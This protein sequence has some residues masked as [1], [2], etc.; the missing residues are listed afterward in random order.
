[1]DCG[2]SLQNSWAEALFQDNWRPYQMS[3]REFSPVRL[4]KE[5]HVRSHEGG[6]KA[7]RQAVCKP[8]REALPETKSPDTL[9]LI[10]PASGATRNRFLLLTPCRLL[11][12]IL[13]CQSRT[14]DTL[15]KR[16]K[17]GEMS[18]MTDSGPEQY[19][20]GP[21]IALFCSLPLLRWTF[22]SRRIGSKMALTVRITCRPNDV[23]R[24]K[25]DH[26]ISVSRNQGI[27]SRAPSVGLTLYVIGQIWVA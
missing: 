12:C 20:P 1:M 2:A 4:P 8:G 9:V 27:L 3:A 22:S 21:R 14:T 10:S 5:H 16:R 6:E 23:L 25:R 15:S 7:G 24:K 18:G 11:D 26:Y 17:V 13:L 19:L